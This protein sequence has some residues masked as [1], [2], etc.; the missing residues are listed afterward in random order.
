[1]VIIIFNLWSNIQLWHTRI[2]VKR[3]TTA[4]FV[5]PFFL[6]FPK[7][8]AVITLVYKGGWSGALA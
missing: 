5:F 8:L 6:I 3:E 7:S 1:M 2:Q 4:F